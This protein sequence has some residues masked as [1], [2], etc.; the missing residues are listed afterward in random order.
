MQHYFV[1]S[2]CALCLSLQSQPGTVPSTQT[3]DIPQFH[4]LFHTPLTRS[5]HHIPLSHI[6]RNK[7]PTNTI[8]R[9]NSRRNLHNLSLTKVLL[10]L[11]EHI[12][13]HTYIQ[14]HRVR[15]AQYSREVSGERFWCGS[16][17]R[18]EYRVHVFRRDT[19]ELMKVSMRLRAAKYRG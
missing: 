15:E 9:P 19:C 14:R 5:I 2:I 3:K 18:F 4:T 16:W 6:Q 13:R 1:R 12:L 8:I 7:H 10:Q 11:R 17:F